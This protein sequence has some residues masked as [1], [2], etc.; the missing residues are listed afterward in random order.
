MNIL[1]LAHNLGWKL[2][3]VING[4]AVDSDKLLDSYTAEV[5]TPVVKLIIANPNYSKND[6]NDS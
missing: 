1:I 5:R 3:V 6:W 4:Q 2:A